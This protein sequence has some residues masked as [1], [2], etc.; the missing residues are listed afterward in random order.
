MKSG[1]T[2]YDFFGVS[3]TA[4]ADQIRSAYL[5]LMKQYH[6]D[7]S[8]Q[9]DRER[10]ADY[11][12]VLNRSYD[13]LKDPQKR[14]NYDAWLDLDSRSRGTAKVRR[15]LLTGETRRK[16]ESAWDA[17]SKGAAVLAGVVLLLLGAALFGPGNSLMHLEAASA[18]TTGAGATQRS[19]ARL[20]EAAL[21]QQV[22]NAIATRSDEAESAS[23]RCFAA[24]REAQSASDAEKCI[25]FD[26]AYLEWNQSAA[27][28]LSRPP[29]F[30][31]AVV[32][33]RHRN[34]M[35]AAGSFDDSRLMQ[36]RQRTLNALLGE[37]SAQVSKTANT[38]AAKVK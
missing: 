4:S 8:N 9:T 11:A 15:A 14:A 19:L 29:Y 18:E 2:Y 5:W 32:R 24:A 25:V 6:P 17:S 20:D 3:R 36:L 10:A 35:A 34:A 31:D 38:S 30:N 22:R 16:R 27:D 21:R 28:V 13:I 12:A 37:V 1:P 23:T 33:L 7:L 26:D